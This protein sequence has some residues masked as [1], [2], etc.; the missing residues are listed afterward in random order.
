VFQLGNRSKIVLPL[1]LASLLLFSAAVSAQITDPRIVEFQPSADHDRMEDGRPIIDRYALEF[2]LVGVGIVLQSVDLGKPAPEADGFIR[3]D[4]GGRLGVWP[5]AGPI[6]EARVVAIGFAGSSAS[7][8]SNSFTF[9]SRPPAQGPTTPPAPDPAPGTPP[10]TPPPAPP[11]PC[12]HDLTP[13]ARIFPPITT[14]ST[15]TVNTGTNCTWTPASSDSW[16]VVTDLRKRTGPGVV[17][18][19]AAEN[20]AGMSRVATITIGTATF[21]LTQTGTCGFNL[22]PASQG[23]NAAGGTGSVVVT[24][25]P[26]CTWNA[27]RSGTWITIT[28]GASGTGNG[29][30]RYRVSENTGASARTGTLTIAG[31]PVTIMQSANTAPN[32]PAGL[33]VVIIR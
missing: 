20:T 16:L 11:A 13:N 1:A 19:R 5:A 3:V 7:A 31:Q 23:F 18:F 28:S 26:V 14:T 25:S 32:T 29:T 24:G 17:T 4:F 10:G 33:R 21:V 22:T 30:V 2:Y 9:P 8:L 12:T 6:Y 15:F 27:V